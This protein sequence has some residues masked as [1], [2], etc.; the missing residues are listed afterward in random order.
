M[1]AIKG[2]GKNGDARDRSSPHGKDV[3][4]QNSRKG[5]TQGKS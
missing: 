2:Q 1:A 4:K 3:V 5:I